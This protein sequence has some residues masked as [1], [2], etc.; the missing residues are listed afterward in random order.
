MAVA[1][2]NLPLSKKR[3][4]GPASC[5]ASIQYLDL[6]ERTVGD[7]AR[8]PECAASP[9]RVNNEDMGL[10]ERVTAR[11]L[12]PDTDQDNVDTSIQRSTFQGAERSTSEFAPTPSL[13]HRRQSKSFGDNNTSPVLSARF[14]RYG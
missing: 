9:S 5:N 6:V 1:D 14:I 7:S 10:R 8:P 11:R 13:A 4:K 3:M 12:C 2:E